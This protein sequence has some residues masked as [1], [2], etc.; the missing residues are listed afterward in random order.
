MK[1]QITDLGNKIKL[2]GYYE[3][4]HFYTS[5]RFYKEKNEY[6]LKSEINKRVILVR[7][8]FYEN[9]LA[10]LNIREDNPSIGNSARLIVYGDTIKT[11]RPRIGGQT[12]G[13]DY[14]YYKIIND[15]TLEFLGFTTDQEIDSKRLQQFKQ[16]NADELHNL[17][18]YSKMRFIPSNDLPDQD[19]MRIKKQKWVWCNEEKYLNYMNN[20]NT[21]S[22]K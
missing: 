6:Q 5:Q 4:E 2:N 9:G 10:F 21:K 19:K 17:G 8:V 16:G 22:P 11:I 14:E 3:Y 20:I 13:L 18:V 1:I 7:S 12:P 15:S